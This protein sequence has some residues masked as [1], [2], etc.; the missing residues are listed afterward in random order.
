MRHLASI[1]RI[2][3]IE[4]I[5]GADR[6]ELAHVLGW[7]CVVSK[8]QF[9]PMNLCVYFEIDSF[10]PER[11]CFEFLRKTSFK[12]SEILGDGFKVRTMKFKGQISQGLCMP[13]S[14]F[15]ELS[16]LDPTDENEIGVDVTGLLGVKEWEVPEKISNLGTIIGN[17]PPFIPTSDETRIQIGGEDLIKEFHGIPYYITTKMDGSSHSCGIEIDGTFHVTGHHYEYADDGKS[18]FYE[19]LKQRKIEEKMRLY[20]AEHDLARM[21]VMGEFCG[22]GLQNN[23]I[24]LTKPEWCIFTVMENDKRVGLAEM[25][26]VSI[27]LGNITVPIEEYGDNFD[28]RYPTV[29]AVLN[30][31]DGFYSQNH[32]KEGIVVRPTEP[33][34]SEICEGYLSFKAVRDRKSVV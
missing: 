29:E 15:I 9:K 8:G 25:Q 10:L 7:Q 30:R 16:V 12:H 27:A 14:D 5:E 20:M 17:K 3:K 2:W 21:V 28:E 4:P 22:P 34:Y 18:P 11:P 32:R 33:R 24:G 6:V 1:Q 13:L 26:K 23:R 19:L 31:A